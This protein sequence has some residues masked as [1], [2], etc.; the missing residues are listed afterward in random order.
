MTF[1]IFAHIAK[2]KPHLITQDGD[3]LVWN[4][5]MQHANPRMTINKKHYWIR[6]EMFEKA[7]GKMPQKRLAIILTCGNPRCI[8]PDHMQIENMSVYLHN[9]SKKTYVSRQKHKGTNTTLDY[10]LKNKADKIQRD[11]DCMIWQSNSKRSPR[12]TL[13]HKLILIRPKIYAEIYGDFDSKKYHVAT[14]CGEKMCINPKHLTLIPRNQVLLDYC[15]SGKN[16]SVSNMLTRILKNHT[17]KL[18]FN[19]VAEIRNSEE[20]STEL[21]HKFNVHVRTIQK[22]RSYSRFKVV[23]S[24]FGILKV[25]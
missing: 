17:R 15:A 9:K 8:N 2:H 10:L 16:K 13:N 5:T 14:S 20:I 23:P 6:R 24:A 22:I 25:A 11:G 18:S 21:A 1:D 3:C 19:D 7:N 12:I 4:G